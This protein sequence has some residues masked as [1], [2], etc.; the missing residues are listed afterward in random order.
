MRRCKLLAM[1]RSR[2]G[3]WLGVVAVALLAWTAPRAAQALDL[4]FAAALRWRGHV[5]TDL[6]F[7]SF[8]TK[9]HTVAFRFMPQYSMA[10]E[11]PIVSIDG[12]GDYVVG[13][14][15]FSSSPSGVK[16]EVRIGGAIAS[17][18]FG[19]PAT[20][21]AK[22]PL[23]HEWH[24]VALVCKGGT[25]KMYV[26]GKH[27]EKSGGGDLAPGAAALAALNG[28]VRLGSD[29]AKLRQF[30]G[31]VDD[32]V[33]LGTALDKAG[34]GDLFAK[35]RLHKSVK[36][37]HLVRAYTFDSTF[38]G[39]EAVSGAFAHAVTFDGTVYKTLVSPDRKNSFDALMMAPAYMPFRAELPFVEGQSWK[40]S[41][42]NEG[43]AS[44][45]GGAAFSFD[46]VRANAPGEPSLGNDVTCGST[47]V[48]TA[49]GEVTD[50]CD[51]GDPPVEHGAPNLAKG[52]APSLG[53]YQS[54]GGPLIDGYDFGHFQVS[55]RRFVY[56]HVKKGSLRAQF[57]THK[58]LFHSPLVGGP[59]YTIHVE[60]GHKVAEAGTRGA[61][62]CHL[63]FSATADGVGVPTAFDDYE[64]LLPG[65]PRWFS[66]SGIPKVGDLIRRPKTKTHPASAALDCPAA[67]K[68]LEE[69]E[70]QRLAHWQAVHAATDDGARVAAAAS[71]DATT[72]ELDR[73]QARLAA[74]PR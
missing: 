73:L 22:K 7:A 66:A 6:S 67:K 47:V 16:L 13:L 21:A 70:A 38:P 74:C 23:E 25:F 32:V 68:A 58:D 71:A 1:M 69:H 27:V 17:F 2:I 53:E 39:G 11:G 34:V 31:L 4:N 61:N 30:Y 49:D 50:G 60:Q 36:A 24:T 65:S 40:V 48:A 19:T 62:N 42:G 54:D 12:A 15:D 46:L 14:G 18:P 59:T 64:Y 52:C 3:R 37:P 63:H 72:Q 56:M 43:L 33:V 28:N 20:D 29:A 55:S 45:H 8:V 57:P 41:Q 44:H 5:D 9:D 10:G 26:D 51:L 35:A